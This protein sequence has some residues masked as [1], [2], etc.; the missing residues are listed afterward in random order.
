MSKDQGRKGQLESRYICTRY[1][2][3]EGEPRA[4]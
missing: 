3:H 1:A 2:T 4:H